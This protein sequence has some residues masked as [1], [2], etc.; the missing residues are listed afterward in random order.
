MAIYHLQKKALTV[1]KIKSSANAIGSHWLGLGRTPPKIEIPAMKIDQIRT[2][3]ESDGY[4]KNMFDIL[5]E[6]I[7]PILKGLFN[8]MFT[9]YSIKANKRSILE[10]VKKKILKC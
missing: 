4:S 3:M 2:V 7:E 10:K 6:E 5:L 9:D 8:T 1:D